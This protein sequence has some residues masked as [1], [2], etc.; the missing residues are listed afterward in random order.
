MIHQSLTATVVQIVRLG[1][2]TLSPDED[3]LYGRNVA[4]NM[5]VTIVRQKIKVNP[6]Y[7]L[8][9]MINIFHKFNLFY[10]AFDFLKTPSLILLLIMVTTFP[11]LSFLLRL[12]S[13]PFNFFIY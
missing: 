12:N 13:F 3:L 6:L 5:K 8:S 4:I 7:T 2:S 1:K 10:P 9:T 11:L